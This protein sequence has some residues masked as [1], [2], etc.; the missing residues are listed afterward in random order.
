MGQ[1]HGRRVLSV[2]EGYSGEVDGDGQIYPSSEEAPKGMESLELDGGP[3]AG[4]ICL[5]STDHPHGDLHAHTQHS[6]CPGPPEGT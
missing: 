6:P 5:L 2:R 1:V 4:G 3:R